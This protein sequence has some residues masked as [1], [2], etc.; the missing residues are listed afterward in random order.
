MK[1]KKFKNVLC[2]DNLHVQKKTYLL[3]AERKIED[4]RKQE[5]VWTN[6]RVLRASEM[7][8]INNKSTATNDTPL[9]HYIYHTN[10]PPQNP[11][12]CI[13]TVVPAIVVVS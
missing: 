9:S 4:F 13:L 11:K 12:N 10:Q 7:N 3:T 2:I 5:E 6:E 8:M 1:N